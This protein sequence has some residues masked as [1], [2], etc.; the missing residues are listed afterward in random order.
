MRQVP[1]SYHPCVGDTCK[2]RIPALLSY[3]TLDEKCGAIC[4]KTAMQKPT[5]ISHSEGSLDIEMAPLA[6]GWQA[7]SAPGIRAGSCERYMYKA[8]IAYHEH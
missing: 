5:G 8:S 4:Q 2:W 6:V 3:S 7:T 1:S